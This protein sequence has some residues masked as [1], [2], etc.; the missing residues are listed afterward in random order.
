MHLL[1]M[2]FSNDNSGG[3]EVLLQSRLPS[4]PLHSVSGPSGLGTFGGRL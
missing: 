3:M 2:T 4:G 1:Q